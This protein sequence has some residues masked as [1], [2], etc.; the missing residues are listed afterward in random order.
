MLYNK[1]NNV[2]DDDG[3]IYETEGKCAK[4]FR[5]DNIALKS[6]KFDCP[7]IYFVS[8]DIFEKLKELDLETIVKLY[9][10]Y[11][12][13]K[14]KI[15]H[16]FKPRVYT[17]EY[18]NNPNICLLNQDKEYLLDVMSKLERDINILTENKIRLFDAHYSNIIFL[19]NGAK[20]IDIDLLRQHK[21]LS[22]KKLLLNNKK[23]L[24]YYVISTLKH[25]L[26]QENLYNYKFECIF[27]PNCLTDL[28][29]TDYLDKTLK[30]DIIRNSVIK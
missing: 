12:F 15:S 14:N 2:L 9:D 18:I 13:Y 26:K 21:L 8:R 11:Y 4:I 23:E 28:T 1:D 25:E 22:A 19:D 24:L 10:Y 30:K 5:K 27:N 29:V 17:M 7:V 20:I 16:I 6:Y 3:F